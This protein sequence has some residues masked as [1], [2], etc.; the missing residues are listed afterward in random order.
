[1]IMAGDIKRVDVTLFGELRNYKTTQQHAP[2]SNQEI[3][4]IPAPLND[5]ITLNREKGYIE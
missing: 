1:M 5:M 2:E 3:T 4:R